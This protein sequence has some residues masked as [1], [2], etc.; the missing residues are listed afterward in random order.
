VAA[1]H[2]GRVDLMALGPIPPAPGEPCN[3]CSLGDYINCAGDCDICGEVGE[4]E[5]TPPLVFE[6]LLNYIADNL[7]HSKRP[8]SWWFELDEPTKERH[9]K[10]GRAAVRQFL[11]REALGRKVC[12]LGS[13]GS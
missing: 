9:R 2:L 10:T 11:T 4:Y 5:P 3:R 12:A 8:L 1:G 7:S 13:E 6:V